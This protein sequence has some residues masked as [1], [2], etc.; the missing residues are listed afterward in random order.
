MIHSNQKD[1]FPSKRWFWATIILGLTMIV[2]VP[3]FHSP[4]EF[5]HFY[6][7]YHIADGHFTP[8]FDSSKARLGGYIPRSL[9]RVGNP[10][11]TIAHTDKK[12][13]LDTIFKYLKSPLL[14]NDK[15]FVAFPNTARYAP[16]AY[17]PQVLAIFILKKWNISPLWMTYLGRFLTFIT[18]FWLIFLAIRWTPMLYRPILMVLTLLPESLAINTTLSADVVTNGFIFLQIALFLQLKT[19]YKTLQPAQRYGKLLLFITLVFFT[20]LHKIVYF[21]LLFLLILLDSAVFNKSITQKYIFIGLNLMANLLLIKGWS[22][23]VHDLIYPFADLAQNTYREM[24]PGYNINPDLQIQYIVNQ[25][26]AFLEK[27]IPATFSTYSHTNQSYIATFGWELI[28]LPAGLVI[29]FLCILLTWIVIQPIQ[30]TRF[31]K[32]ILLLIAHSMTSLF[33]LSMYLHWDSVGD[34]ITDIYTAKYY[35]APYALILLILGGVL[36]KW[37]FFLNQ[38][39]YIEITFKVSF[40]VTW[41]Y[42][43]ILV[44]QRY[45]GTN[46]LP[47]NLT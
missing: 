8:D 10:F 29:P 9:V 14:P 20:T 42:F 6:K 16:T 22:S 35:F 24:R 23:H 34:E 17:A 7:A 39:K 47:N 18:W 26:I 3:P 5:N 31:E 28:R 37:Q 45:Y 33:L 11:D 36:T 2:L 4:D 27:F 19:D 15:I 13:K 46:I 41:C 32:G 1:S 30:W 43:L 12:M 38:K 44:Y 25:P 21:P 40:V